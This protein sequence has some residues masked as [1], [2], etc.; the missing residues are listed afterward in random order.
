M[1]PGGGDMDLMPWGALWHAFASL[2]S[3][4]G[5]HLMSRLHP[6]WHPG[7]Y[8][9]TPPPMQVPLILMNLMDL[10]HLKSWP[11]GPALYPLDS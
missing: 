11:W 5:P 3:D 6:Q 1:G 4:Q 7:L 9:Q 2:D 10:T 8:I